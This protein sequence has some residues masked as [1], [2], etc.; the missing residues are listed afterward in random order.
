MKLKKIKDDLADNIE[1]F[2]EKVFNKYVITILFFVVIIILNFPRSSEN[3]YNLK[4]G[5]IA[6]KTIRATVS[7]LVEDKQATQKRIEE[8]MNNTPPVF[9]YNANVFSNAIDSLK[10]ALNQINDE[11]LKSSEKKFFEILKI[12]PSHPL[13]MRILRYNKDDIFKYASDAL[14]TLQHYYIVNSVRQLYKF[15]P[16]KIII[17]SIKNPQ[18]ERLLSKDDV[19]DTTRAKIIAYNRLKSIV[20]DV[21]LRNTVWDLISQL[22]VPNLTFNSLATRQKKQEAAK[23]VNKVFFKISKGEIIVRSGDVITKADYLKLNALNSLK[24]KQ[25]TYIKFV[26][27][28][29]LFMVL[30]FILYEVYRITKAKKNKWISEAKLLAITESLVVIQILL[31][32]L[33]VYLS[34]VITFSNVDLPQTAVLFATPFAVASMMVAIMIDFELA[35]LVSIL[36]GVSA[37]LLLN[38]EMFFVGVYVF[39]GNIAGIFGIRKEKTRTGVIKAGLYVSLSSLLFILLFYTLKNGEINKSMLID[40]AFG[41]FG[42]VL[43][44]IIV[45]GFLPVF[46]Y[47]FNITTDIKLLELGNLNN[48]LL[49]EL[50]IKAPGTYHHSIVVSSLAEAA[51]TQIGANPL[52]VKVG[53][54]Y[55]DIG[56]I[57]K[58]L[59]FIE[60][61]VD[62]INPHDKLKPSISALIIKNHVKYGVEIA[63]K[64]RLGNYIIDIIQQHH[65][66]S[67]IKYFYNK[68]KENGLNPKEEDFRYPGPKP[69]TKEAGIVMI[70]DEVEAASKTLSNPTVAHLRDFV[71]DITNKIFLDGQLD[72]CELTLKDL[73]LI[74]DSFVKVL[75]GIFHH[76]IEYPEDEKKDNVAGETCKLNA[77][78][79]NEFNPNRTQG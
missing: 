46:E 54:Y 6:P 11:D 25:N 27:D 29:L 17:R 18:K 9:D 66:T 58:P 8:A 35:F 71:R 59:Y 50:A 55:H 34:N 5:D 2:F 74:V 64:H 31:F 20:D 60:N 78:G 42:G 73:N 40:L 44:A 48:P 51:A 77:K 72:E 56:K 22:I 26:A 45:S 33:F 70:A 15:S 63:K 7:M 57:K 67:L 75:V 1:N 52:I 12:K 68:A 21:S 65:G 79:E 62:G 4:I 28:M 3:Y 23:K 49:K 13:F 53:S 61:Q 19:I 36:F 32:K 38:P 16:D 24:Q 14:N 39:L 47:A 76:R 43:S 10:K 30:C 41:S 37:W 69:Q